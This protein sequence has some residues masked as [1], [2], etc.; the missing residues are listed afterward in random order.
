MT[1]DIAA[2]PLSA[3]GQLGA[4]PA[5]PAWLA[6]GAPALRDL[7]LALGRLLAAQ[8]PRADELALRLAVLCSAQLSEGR[9]CLDLAAMLSAPDRFVPADW[10]HTEPAAAGEAVLPAWWPQDLSACRARLADCPFVGTGEGAEPLVLRGARLYLARFWRAG[11]RIR[12][13]LRARLAPDA[14]DVPD[15]AIARSWMDRVFPAPVDG[16]LDW[17][18]I[19]VAIALRQRLSII[20]GG[21]GTGKTTTVVRLLAVLQGLAQARGARLRI[22][23][24]A[25]TGKAAARLNASIEGRLAELASAADPL[26]AQALSSVP[27]QVETLHALL[28]SRPGTRA[29][30]Y[31]AGRPLDLDVLVV[32]EASMM[33]VEMM[34]ALLAALPAPARLILLGDRDQL[35][36]VEAGAILGELCARAAE[37]HYRPQTCALLQSLCGQAPGL[38]WQDEAGTEL[39]QA[40]VMLRVSHRFSAHSGIGRFA[41]AVNTGDA[42][43]VAALLAERPADLHCLV[44]GAT[45][46][47]D[48]V[49]PGAAMAWLKGSRILSE[50]GCAAWFKVLQD[51]RPEPQAD[52]AQWDQWARRVLA[53]QSHFQ[54]LCALRRGRWG[55][56]GLNQQIEGALRQAGLIQPGAGTWYPGRPILVLRNQPALGLSNGDIGVVLSRPDPQNPACDLVRVAFSSDARIR[57]ISPARL[58][59]VDTVYALT[60]HKSQGSEFDHVVLVLPDQPGPLLTRELLYTGATRARSRL[61][62]VLPGGLTLLNRAVRHRA[63]RGGGIWQVA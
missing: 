38:E 36:S 15:P 40:V 27:V 42:A 4:D 17:Q 55:A 62:L 24:A 30:A 33:D 57:W 25:P 18:R 41:H 1:E 44:P 43:A 63:L 9:P 47:S 31:H 50:D 22:R 20:T 58:T 3:D 59:E 46:P 2:E 23:L 28:G 53:A 5:I 54:V 34:D 19:A 35:A 32:D 45:P 16:A 13:A 52:E 61:T 39:D 11:V 21:P 12:G 8:V 10:L 49:A 37:G 48:T 7:D 60:V 14:G 26:L 56:E 6:W 51:T 29:L